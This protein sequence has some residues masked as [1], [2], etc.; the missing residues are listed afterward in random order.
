MLFKC[1]SLEK[2]NIYNLNTNNV[3]NMYHMFYGC[4]PLKQLNVS[5]FNIE[6]NVSM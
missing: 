4:S 5:N 2:I 1:L 3:N 6:K